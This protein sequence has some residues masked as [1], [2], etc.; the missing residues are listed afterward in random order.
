MKIIQDI[1]EEFHKAG[2]MEDEMICMEIIK[3]FRKQIE[4]KA[5]SI[6]TIR[7]A[8]PDDYKQTRYSHGN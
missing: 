8:L 3:G 7:G 1:A 4:A 6:T 5:I 2:T